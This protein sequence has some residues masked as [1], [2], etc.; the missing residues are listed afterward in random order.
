MKAGKPVFS[1]ASPPVVLAL[2]I[3]LTAAA[4]GTARRSE[5][6][7]GEHHLA[8]AQLVRGEIVYSLQCA[9]C[10][11]GGEAGLGPSINDKPLPTWLIRFQ[12]RNGLGV[13]PAFSREQISPEDLDA[14]ILYLKVLRRQDPAGISPPTGVNR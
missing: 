1:R 9:Q 12:V 6:L 2:S 13:M 3:L 14:L 11:P 7:T 10:H 8:S 4:C 5:P